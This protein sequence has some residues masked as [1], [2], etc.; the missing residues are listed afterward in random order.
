LRRQEHEEYGSTC[1]ARCT[2]AYI[3]GGDPTAGG[4]AAVASEAAAN[5]LTN[6]L[7][8]KYKDDPK[9]FVNGEF[10]ANLLSEAEKAQIRD[11]T[12]GIGGA[13]GDSSYNAKLAGVIGQNAVE[14][15]NTAFMANP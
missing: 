13:V 1:H 3:N 5:Y 11:L 14:N 9:Y 15:N 2:L 12:A 6:Q 10:Q 8:E 4:S 7:A